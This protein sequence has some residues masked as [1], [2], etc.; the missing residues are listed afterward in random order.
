MILILGYF[1]DNEENFEKNQ[2]NE[3]G[4]KNI[5]YIDNNGKIPEMELLTKF[6]TDFFLE[7]VQTKNDNLISY[8]FETAGKTIATNGEGANMLPGVATTL[9]KNSTKKLYP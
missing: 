4:I 9:I 5:I 3:I 1:L 8:T 7:D 6:F 2:L